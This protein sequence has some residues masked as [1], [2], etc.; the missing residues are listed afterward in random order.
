MSSPDKD[1]GVIA[2]LLHRL[3]TDRLPTMLSLK[4]KVDAGERLSDGDIEYLNRAIADAKAAGLQP[5]LERHPEYRDLVTALFSMYGQI[6][7]RALE[8]ESLPNE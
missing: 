3:E 5:L 1:I 2:V 8:N 6:I 4:K 7:D